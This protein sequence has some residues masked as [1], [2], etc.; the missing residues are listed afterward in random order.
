M[1]LH[2]PRSGRLRAVLEVAEACGEHRLATHAAAIAFRIL[3]SLVPLAL[4][5]LALL[6]ALGLEDVW[7]DSIAPA[8][9]DRVTQPVFAALDYSVQ[10]IMSSNTAGVIAF[11]SL[12]LL[13]E[14]SR[15]VRSVMV[16]LNEI[17]DVEER[18]SWAELLRTTLWLAVATGL[19]VMAA[20]VAVIVLPRLADGLLRAALTLAAYAVAVALLG[21]VIALL[22][23]YAPA[24]Q[25]SPEWASVGSALVVT[26]WL[27]ASAVF[28][29]WAGSVA[30]YKTA[31]GSLTVFLVLTAYTFASAAIFLVGVEVD[32]RAR[33]RAT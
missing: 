10:R 22:V 1:E 31:V 5:G 25:P 20:L 3:V 32:E 24:E 9:Q 8:V 16:A 30:S 19:G 27:G 33:T 7:T 6:G 23:R 21:V 12:L 18:R 11:A 13:W 29:W 2:V 17:H 4:L 28:G 14:L 26:A 15:G